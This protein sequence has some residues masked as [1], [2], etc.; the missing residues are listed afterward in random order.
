[1][2]AGI[3]GRPFLWPEGWQYIL[4]GGIN[5]SEHC[6]NVSLSRAHSAHSVRMGLPESS[7]ASLIEA[8]IL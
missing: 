8:A 1:M 4:E 5:T 2:A 6:Q 7:Q 3:L